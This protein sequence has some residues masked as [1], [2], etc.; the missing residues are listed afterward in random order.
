[1]I[2][3]TVASRTQFKPHKR[4]QP[5]EKVFRR[6]YF[7]VL[8]LL[9]VCCILNFNISY[10]VELA[11]TQVSAEIFLSSERLSATN[12]LHFFYHE[13]L[14]SKNLTE[15]KRGS[16]HVWPEESLRKLIDERLALLEQTHYELRFGGLG[17]VVII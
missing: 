16:A 13:L 9:V 10:K 12:Q 11:N 3:E 6:Y 17:R 8:P 7:I 14:A 5:M 2:L 15:N 1:M 4:Q